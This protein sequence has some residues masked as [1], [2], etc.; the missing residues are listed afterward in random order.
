MFIFTSNLFRRYFIDRIHSQPVELVAISMQQVKLYDTSMKREG[1]ETFPSYK[2]TH[3][4]SLPSD[5]Q[6]VVGDIRTS[7]TVW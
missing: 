2:E 4:R 5:S 3:T 6:V 7:V 1:G